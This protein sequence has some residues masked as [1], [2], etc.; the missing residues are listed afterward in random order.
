MIGAYIYDIQ[1][2]VHGLVNIRFQHTPRSANNLAHILAIETLRRREET[3]LE[4]G[5]PDY[6]EDQARSDGGR[7]P[8]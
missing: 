6:A 1:Q 5:L 4:M 2:K 8:D 3:Y 7:E